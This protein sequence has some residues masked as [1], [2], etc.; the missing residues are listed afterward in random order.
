MNFVGYATIG[1]I[2]HLAGPLYGRDFQ[3][4]GSASLVLS[5]FGNLRRMAPSDR[6]RRADSVLHPEPRRGR[7][8]AGAE[9]DQAATAPP[10]AVAQV[11]SY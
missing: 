11:P 10:Q 4:V 1:G 5:E 3:T 2:G 6:R 7:G 8:H 9:V